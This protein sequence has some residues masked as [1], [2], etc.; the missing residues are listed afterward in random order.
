M[1]IR[2]NSSLLA[3]IMVVM[4]VFVMMPQ[5][6]ASAYADQ[7]FEQKIDGVWYYLYPDTHTAVVFGDSEDPFTGT[8]LVIPA[9][10]EYDS[11]T[12][13]VQ[14]I[15]VN[16][17]Q[18]NGSIESLTVSEGVTEIGESAFEYCPNLES[19]T[20][21]ESLRIIRAAAFNDCTKLNNIEL[22]PHLNYIGRIA[23]LN[24]AHFSDDSKWDDDVLYINTYLIKAHEQSICDEY[25]VKEG[26]RIIAGEAFKDCKELNKVFIPNSVISISEEAFS[27]CTSLSEVTFENDSNLQIIDKYAFRD[28]KKL[29]SIELPEGLEIINEHVFDGCELLK[30][31]TIPSTVTEV[32]DYAFVDT[33]IGN[34]DED[35]VIHFGGSPSKWE[36]ITGD[37]KPDIEPADYGVKDTITKMDIGNVWT[38]LSPTK[39]IAYTTAFDPDGLLDKK[40]EFA[41]QFWTDTRTM[42]EIHI[43]DSTL[44]TVGHTYAFS[45]IIAPKNGYVFD[46]E[47]FEE[48][49]YGG[50]TVAVD[51]YNIDL[52][53]NGCILLQWG[54]TATSEPDDLNDADFNT[55]L[56]GI[57]SKIYNGK[58][59][60]QSVAVKIKVNGEW[61]TLKSGT[62]YKLSYKNNTNAGTATVSVKGKGNFKGTCSEPFTISKAA[63]PLKVSPMTASVKYKKLKKKNQTLA[64]TKVIEFTKDAKDKKKYKLLSAKK[65]S[66]SFKKYFTISKTT[67]KVTV[68]KALKKGTYNVTVKVKGKGNGNYKSSAWKKVT[69][70]IKVK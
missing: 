14:R 7:S 40:M 3:M 50:N 53:D 30:E 23:F 35:A 52:R 5:M 10:I 51:A 56:S 4:M 8:E 18:S 26:T 1:N 55:T 21:P 32:N 17:F 46:G 34:R 69:F 9:T 66:K 15:G 44:P 39:G 12:F 37:G 31:V 57:K 13:A 48:F 54:V 24:T 60:T 62:D 68:K 63:N 47:K 11:E 29:L 38:E 67:G 27:L 2:K 65:G 33:P 43:G 70:K 45:V 6:A 41:D 61:R 25:N 49:I 22:P 42:E 20:L 59:Q 36:A 64:V 28:N 19:I 16:A 58:A